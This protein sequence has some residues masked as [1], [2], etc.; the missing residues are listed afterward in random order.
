MELWA[1][2]FFELSTEM[3]VVLGSHGRILEANPAW[4]A[5]VGWTPVELKG[6]GYRSFIHPEDL[7]TV[8]A[9]LEALL[10]A[11]GN[12][13]LSFRWRCRDG[14]WA[15]L[16]WSVAGSA[17]GGPLYCTA[18]RMESTPVQE[19]LRTNAEATESLDPPWAMSD[20]LPLG[21]YV[22]DVRTG[23]VL[24]ANRR[25]C[26]LWGIESLE[27]SLRRGVLSHEEVLRQCL[28]AGEAAQFLRLH[29]LTG[30]APPPLHGDEAVL[31]NGRTLRR[32]STPMGTRG[33]ESRFRLFAFEDVTE[34]KR[35]E[36]ALHRSEQSF[37]KLIEAAPEVIFVHRDQRFIYVNPTLLKALRYDHASELIGRPIWSIVHPDDLDMV[38]QRVH[39]VVARGEL[40]PLREIRYMRRDGTW[41][42]AESAGLPV[43]FDGV[44][45]VVVM[46]RDITE[47]KRMQAQLLQS[48]R[49]VLAGTLAAGVGHEIN[50]PLTYVLA[51]L[52][53][54][55]ESIHRLGGELG[56]TLPDGDIAPNWSMSLK[57]TVDLLREAHEG[58]TRVRNIVRDLKYISRQEEERRELLD[59]RESLEFSLKLASSE[60]KPRAQVIKQYESVPPVY[61][62]A[63]RLGQVFLNLV[64][65]AAQAIPE[66][67]PARHR[68]T[69]WVRPTPAGGV[70]VD[71]S[72]TGSGMPPSVMA[73]IF[74]P[75]FTTKAVGAGT[76]LGLSICHGIIKGLGGDITVNSEPGQ[77]TTFTVT[78]PPAPPNAPVREVPAA[79]LPSS[80]RSGRMLVIDDEPA[81]GRSLARIIGKRHHV[82]VV[83]SGEEAL[84]KLASGAEFDAIFCDLMMPGIT[85]MDV[86]ERVR[87]RE[88]GLGLRF[89]FITGGSYTARARQFLERVPNPRIEKPFDAQ[90]IQQIVGEVLAVEST[91]MPPA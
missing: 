17:V 65:N 31:A 1:H 20:S 10:H 8:D 38:R 70:A 21:L 84:L 72:D 26:Q 75:F 83:G 29:P 88:P 35:T 13:R 3:F 56:R 52:D 15:W 91:D 43:D 85:G 36:E 48:D 53:S 14:T 67:D 58:A 23:T 59:V 42:D 86:Y 5:T 30:D 62:D 50:N 37:R 44:G 87:E 49:M 11:P 27:E 78:L 33:D 25:F 80:E 39:A 66:G 46:A 40:A 18:R 51:N 7:A 81:V 60:M 6:E 2:R 34:R 90:M 69:L 9:R 24:Y 57:D 47:R 64:V 19:K 16:A 63:S 54:A 28:R 22:V 55:M 89:I 71:V 68:V 4:G 82:T 45:A 79:P 61:A 12:T 76:G 77:G 32:L 73:R 74:D 41:F